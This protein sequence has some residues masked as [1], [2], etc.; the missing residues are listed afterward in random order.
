MPSYGSL[1]LAYSWM[2]QP[3]P[4]AAPSFRVGENDSLI[5]PEGK[6]LRVEERW[7]QANGELRV[8]YGAKVVECRRCT[9]AEACLGEWSSAGGGEVSAESRGTGAGRQ[10]GGR[11]SADGRAGAS[12]ALGGYRRTAR[13]ARACQDAAEAAGQPDEPGAADRGSSGQDR[14]VCKE[15]GRTSASAPELGEPTGAECR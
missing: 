10:G 2:K 13:S 9:V 5:C 12:S 14:S 7:V 1:R 4:Y 8:L 15:P 6:V 3:T 11:G